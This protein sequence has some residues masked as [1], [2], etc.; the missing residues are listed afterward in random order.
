MRS[1]P[2]V[3]P[4]Q[5]PPFGEKGWEKW[6][7][8]LCSIVPGFAK[9]MRL[10][11]AAGAEYDWRLFGSEDYN[12]KERK[13]LE[14]QLLAHMKKIVP[15]KYH[16]ILTPDYGVG[17]KRRIF[18]ATCKYF[19]FPP[20]NISL[21]YYLLYRVATNSP[22]Q[23]V[24]G[25]ERPRSRIDNATLDRHWREHSYPWPWTNLSRPE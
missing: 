10:L 3:V 20:G 5:I 17:C 2:W 12:A 23:R 4:R 24:P 6:S 8:W 9:A 11:V 16:E 19:A 14:D 22:T 13:K 7:P 18:D 1:P 15:K 25:P 21:H